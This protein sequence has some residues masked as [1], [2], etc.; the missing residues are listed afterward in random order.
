MQFNPW[1]N[2]MGTDGFE[3]I[4]YAAPDPAALGRLFAGRIGHGRVVGHARAGVGCGRLPW[5]RALGGVR[6]V[7]LRDERPH[8]RELVGREREGVVAQPAAEAARARASA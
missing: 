6:A 2:P 8:R 4:E 5:R 3:F 7:E 1:D